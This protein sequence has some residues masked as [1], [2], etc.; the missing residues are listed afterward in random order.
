MAG[1][2]DVRRVD[3]EVPA[4]QLPLHVLGPEDAS[5]VPAL[6]VIP[7]IFGPADDLL[8]RLAELA[9]DTL[10][11]VPDPFWRTGE[12]AM[13]YDDLDAAIGRLAEFDLDACT[14]EMAATVWWARQQANGSVVAVGICFG[15]PFVLGLAERHEVDGIVTWHGSRMEQALD[16]AARI[17]CPVRHHLGGAD[18]VTPPEVVDRLRE[19]FAGHDDAQIVVHEG[20]SHGFSHDGPAYDETAERAGFASVV[21]L[22][23]RLR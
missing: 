7:S 11:V 9:G 22:L 18:P 10:V 20:A 19:A 17:T 21:E 12:G 16:N 4:G 2:A 3:I 1:G 23:D 8:G 14:A 5:R 13:P 6:V 15:G